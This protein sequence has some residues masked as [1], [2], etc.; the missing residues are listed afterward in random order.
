VAAR[1]L[2]PF[3]REVR[4]KGGQSRRRPHAS[5]SGVKSPLPAAMPLV[6]AVTWTVALIVDGGPFDSTSV[7][8]MCV[9]L[10]GMATTSVA[11]IV[12]AGGRWARR[13]G[14][15]LVGATALLAIVR[16]IDLL[17]IIG[18]VTTALAGLS[19]NMASVTN[20]VRK[21]P[22]A[23]GPPARSVLVPLILL[24]TPFVLGI[25]N[26]NSRPWVILVVGLSAP[27]AAFAYSRVLPGGLLAV[28]LLWPALAIIAAYPMGAP[29]GFVSV[30]L[31]VLIA[32]LAWD[33]TVKTA[34]HPPREVGSSYPIPPELAPREILDEAGI[35]DRGRPSAPRDHP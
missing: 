31:G 5:D 33:P 2:A 9:G 34:F 27:L 35:D 11:G 18:L 26:S 13:L 19:L 8:L 21:L 14:L 6:A 15:V 28:R 32:A 24:G 7:F 20:R 23:A 22:A 16:P 1:R 10:L 29:G 25:A 3:R 12:V 30:S 4:S 17:W